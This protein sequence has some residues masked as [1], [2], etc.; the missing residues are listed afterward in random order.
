MS[1]LARVRDCGRASISGGGDVGLRLG[2][3]SAGYSGLAHCGS[4]WACPVCSA[5]IAA[6]R[7]REVEHLLKWN[8]DRGG[9]VALATF[10]LS[11]QRA[12]KLKDL[13]RSL[14]TA[15]RHMTQSRAWK[16]TRAELGLDGYVRALECTFTDNG[17]HLHAHVLLLFDGPVSSEVIETWT[18]QLFGLWSDGLAKTGATAS[19]A[20]GVDVRLGTGALDGLGKYLSKLTYEHTGGRYKRGRTTEAGARSR[21]P[22]ELLDDAVATGLA[23]DWAAWF[24]WEQGSKGMQ[25]LVWSNGLKDRCGV[26]DLDDQEIAEQEIEGED[27]VLIEAESWRRLYWQAADL[28]TVAETWGAKSALT[29][30][31]RHGY[32]WKWHPNYQGQL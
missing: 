9:S 26:D 19:R 6:Q 7:T 20:R 15:W 22:F 24:E 16:A 29:W 32:S 23:E 12:D 5:K 17:W 3:G 1:N 13:R 8:A 28:L 18:D 27:L 25:Q 31:D 30:L 21:T 11:H 2:A 10:T 14:S 4:C